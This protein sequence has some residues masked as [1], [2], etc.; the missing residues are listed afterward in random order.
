MNKC[1]KCNIGIYDDSAVCP[2]CHSGLS[3]ENVLKGSSRSVMYPEVKDTIKKL[4]FATRIVIFA[5]IFVEIVAIFVNTLTFNGIYW[6]FLSGIALI[7]GVFSLIY[8]VRNNKSLQR[9]IVVQ[10]MLSEFLTIGVDY[11]LGYK[12]WS[13]D[14]AIPFEIISVDIG[15]LVLM[16][17]RFKEWTSFLYPIIWVAVLSFLSFILDIFI[18]KDQFLFPTIAVILSAMFIVGMIILGGKKA[19]SEIERRFHI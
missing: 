4:R 11:I 2:I 14:Y 17:I 9:K 3:R 8:S 18:G 5:A 15:I 7:Y 1:P 13:I 12:G 6:S 10:L 16:I 19:A